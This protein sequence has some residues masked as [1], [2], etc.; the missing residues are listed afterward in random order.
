[1]KDENKKNILLMMRIAESFYMV[2]FL[3]S[4]F[5]ILLRFRFIFKTEVVAVNPCGYRTQNG[6]RKGLP[7]QKILI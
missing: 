5:I 6:N 1:M 3:I 2:V 7:L 4:S